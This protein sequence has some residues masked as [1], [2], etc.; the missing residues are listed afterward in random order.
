[1]KK[2]IIILIFL[3]LPL[4]VFAT[5]TLP[6]SII[7]TVKA[8]IEVPDG[9]G[10]FKSSS[11][12]VNGKTLWSL[13]WSGENK[14]QL[15][16]AT[17]ENGTIISLS[18]IQQ[19]KI[20]NI[21]HLPKISKIEA[22]QTATAFVV[23]VA[24]DI[25][26]QLD[27]AT[28]ITIYDSGSPSGYNVRF[29]RRVDSINYEGDTIFVWVDAQ[30]GK[31]TRYNRNFN[32]DAQ[33][34]SAKNVI[35][36]KLAEQK[37]IENIGIEL[38]YNKKIINE[39]VVP[40]L[41]YTVAKSG[42]I[43][44]VTGRAIEMK[45]YIG[46]DGYFDIQEMYQKSAATSASENADVSG[47]MSG[48]EAQ[49]Y[50]R[51]IPE[52]KIDD[53]YK[54]LQALYYKNTDGQY[55][56]TLKFAKS[57]E[58]FI[59]VVLDAK[60]K[61]LKAFLRSKTPVIKALTASIT[62]TEAKNIAEAYS[63]KYMQSY[64]ANFSPPQIAKINSSF[65]VLYER[66]VNGIPY[67]SNGIHFVMDISG[68][69]ISISFAWDNVEFPKPEEALTKV[70]AYESFFKNIGL[71]LKFMKKD[72]VNIV[73]VYTTSTSSTGIID[74]KTGEILS[75]DG[76]PAKKQQRLAYV[77]LDTHYSKKQVTALADCDIYVSQGD[78]VLDDDIKQKD[79]IRL[80]A[81]IATK[82][83][84][85][86]EKFGA[87]TDVELDMLYNAFVTN[88]VMDRSEIAPDSS[89]TR[90]Q[91]VKYFIRAV[92][93]KNVAELQGI[94]KMAFLDEGE[95]L[96]ELYGYVALAKGLKLIEGSEGYFWPK[97]PL[98]NADSLIMVYNYMNR[99]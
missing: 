67:K 88:G 22:S 77:G 93:Y 38:R 69:I 3:W 16:I 72:D 78:V 19:S 81:T 83:M 29:V 37:F 60:T 62:E 44:A 48:G 97:R 70:L 12:I 50:A 55:L 98:S 51:D 30:T 13:S 53:S 40:Y 42:A 5:D 11:T 14:A 68:N 87:I 82:R 6:Q 74:A 85:I 49:T 57:N 59:E 58:D 20:N 76:T 46:I 84:P 23:L 31:V 92:G 43:D 39:K 33:F 27:T 47:L 34:A 90:E 15:N 65:V 2:L 95:M 10:T 73:P 75:Y 56:I 91:A 80:L 25:I 18:N 28:P 71:K 9:L 24:N 26:G 7:D 64:Y 54:I 66:K 32:I 21:K 41:V 61:E 36:D 79:Y 99:G 89:V 45:N 35:D 96:P 63:K 4:C 17:D 52:L 86:Y 94:F 8:K 1:M